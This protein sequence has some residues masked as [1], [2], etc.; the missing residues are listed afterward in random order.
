M[1]KGI[2][3]MK[4]AISFFLVVSLLI[5]MLYGSILTVHSSAS[6]PIA[7]MI[8]EGGFSSSN[9]TGDSGTTLL[10]SKGT[11]DID[12]GTIRF[13]NTARQAGAVV[14]RNQVKLTDGFSTYF[15]IYFSSNADGIA[16]LLYKADEPKLGDYGGA[17]GYADA[18]ADDGVDK[19][20][21]NSIVVEFDTWNNYEG[22]DGQSWQSNWNNHV[23]IMF[24]GNAKHSTQSDSG[25]AVS[26][27]AGLQGNYINAWVDYD[28][29]IITVTYG[30]SAKRSEG[31][32]LTRTI[33]AGD[34]VPLAGDDVY[35]GF[36][37]STGDNVTT[38]KLLKWYFMDT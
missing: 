15:K 20:I 16:F 2:L 8:E 29:S 35:I 33:Q 4:K 12:S 22:L 25:N 24:E 17:L 19:A 23:G 36:T 14:K 38:H 21:G 32:T 30:T 10:W 34:N 28:G 18:D 26:L 5:T 31:T 7:V 27:S 37:S 13:T 3:K 1:T 9:T 6:T 11:T